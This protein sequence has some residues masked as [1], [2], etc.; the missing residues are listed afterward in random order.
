[1]PRPTL[2]V[3]SR[4]VRTALTRLA[5]IVT[6]LTLAALSIASGG[7]V[8]AV[9]T[10][11]GFERSDCGSGL[12]FS[13]PELRRDENQLPKD[14]ID[15]SGRIVGRE[16]LCQLDSFI[17]SNDGWHVRRVEELPGGHPQYRPIDRRQTLES[18]VMQVSGNHVVETLL[19]LFDTMDNSVRVLRDGRHLIV[20]RGQRDPFGRH[21][22]GLARPGLRFEQ[23][24]NGATARLVPRAELLETVVAHARPR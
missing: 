2:P 19:I 11:L 4:G 24:V 20:F 10:L 12:F 15:E 5:T 9:G 16:F 8:V 18:P 17:H 6:T 1:M 14:A 7:A 22:G 13:S 23:E 21:C 3:G